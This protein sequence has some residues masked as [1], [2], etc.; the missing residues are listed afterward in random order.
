MSTNKLVRATWTKVIWTTILATFLPFVIVIGMP[1]TL[2]GCP[3]YLR[4]AQAQTANAVAEAANSALPVLVE[5]YRQEGLRAIDDVKAK[6]GT[7]QEARFAIESVKTKWKPIWEA[8]AALR[9]AEDAWADALE[10]DTDTAAA[11]AGLRSA[12]CQFMARWPSAVP[13]IP[14]APVICGSAT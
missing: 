11:L 1:L 10:K 13:V 4:Q 5:A 6:G 7:E 14:L 8:W 9:I 2:S 12:Y 3:D